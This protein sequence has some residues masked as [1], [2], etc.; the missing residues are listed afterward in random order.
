MTSEGLIKIK[1]AVYSNPM[2]SHIFILTNGKLALDTSE[3]PL[4]FKIFFFS[5]FFFFR[6]VW[7]CSRWDR[8]P[9]PPPLLPQSIRCRKAAC[10]L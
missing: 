6:P 1:V 8:V 5:F 2:S 9:D 4:F 3:I 10:E 7:L